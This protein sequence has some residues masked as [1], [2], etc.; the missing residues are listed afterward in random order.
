[1]QMLDSRYN[2]SD[3]ITRGRNEVNFH[4]RDIKQL[5]HT[6]KGRSTMADGPASV[7]RLILLGIRL[8]I[9]FGL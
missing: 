8:I 4:G 7:K 3:K 1:M 9:R 6:Y 2:G 5:I